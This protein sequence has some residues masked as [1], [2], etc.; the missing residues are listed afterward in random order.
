[1]LPIYEARER[2]ADF[3]GVDGRLVAAAAA[4][5]AGGRPVAWMPSFDAARALLADWLR[6]G[7]ICLVMGAGDIDALARSLVAQT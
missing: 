5:A 7:D 1:V 4:D 6:E 3:P 2:P